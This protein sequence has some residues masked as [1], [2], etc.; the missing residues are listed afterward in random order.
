[1]ATVEMRVRVK[2]G[3]RLELGLNVLLGVQVKLF[4]QLFFMAVYTV[5]SNTFVSRTEGYLCP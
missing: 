3:V 5:W 1:M 2:D 4:S